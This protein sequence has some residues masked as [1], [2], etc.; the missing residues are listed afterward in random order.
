L[1]KLDIDV[2]L[3]AHCSEQNKTVNARWAVLLTACILAWGNTVFPGD[4]KI[5]SFFSIDMPI[6]VAQPL[7]YLAVSLLNIPYTV[8]HMSSASVAGILNTRKAVAPEGWPAGVS[9]R[10]FI[11]AGIHNNL[12][13][14]APVLDS[15]PERWP[16]VALYRILKLL[17]DV[18]YIGLGPVT[19]VASS[20]ALRTAH[21]DANLLVWS[22]FVGI[23][24]LSI[25]FSLTLLHQI[26]WKYVPTA[27]GL[28]ET[29][30]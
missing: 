27:L 9:Y 25:L 15:V 21:Q 14:I 4:A 17:V 18:S 10:A 6:A 11:D 13:R 12:V 24:A 5:V 8:A 30:R 19:I 20:V 3:A 1:D 7:L 29:D 22:F 23:G 28:I 2:K 16:R 26:V